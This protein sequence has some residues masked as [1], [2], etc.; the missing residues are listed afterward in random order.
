MS[1]GLPVRPQA[2]A[3]RRGRARSHVRSRSRRR[4]R[5]YGF[6]GSDRCSRPSG[7]WGDA[8]RLGGSRRPCSETSSRAR[9]RQNHS[10]PGRRPGAVSHRQSAVQ[11]GDC[12]VAAI[13]SPCR[14]RAA[15]WTCSCGRARL[16]SFT[17]CGH[18]PRTG[19]HCCM[20]DHLAAIR[21]S[22]HTKAPSVA[23]FS[24]GARWVGPRGNKARVS[25]E[26]IKS[27][28]ASRGFPQEP[29]WRRHTFHKRSP[30]NK[31][32]R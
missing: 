27:W 3:D 16:G 29:L 9:N 14:P 22:R 24:F 31:K 17:R 5:E 6:P 4:V 1:P 25:A 15:Y 2:S 28:C 10:R 20:G 11:M 18:E 7:M 8:H 21:R 13:V 19:R 23:G 32:S 26:R 12:G 30:H